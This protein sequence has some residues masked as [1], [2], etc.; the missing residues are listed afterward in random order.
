MYEDSLLINSQSQNSSAKIAIVIDNIAIS[1]YETEYEGR[2]PW[3]QLDDRLFACNIGIAF[4][5]SAFYFRMIKDTV[6]KLTDTGVVRHLI[7]TRVLIRR[8]YPQDE[9]EPKVFDVDDLL[10]GFNIFLGFCGI[11]VIVFC[12]EVILGI[13][14]CR[15]NLSFDRLRKKFS[16]K[17]EKCAQIH[18]KST[19]DGL[20]FVRN[21]QKHSDVL[22]KFRIRKKV[23][24]NVQI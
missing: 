5:H 10:F 8:K 24:E 18:P 11:C 19:I 13:K 22:S 2:D 20:I 12:V 6:D 7:K 23:V 1:Y 17:K 14:V 3:N 15:T 21:S 9:P 16:N 4:Q